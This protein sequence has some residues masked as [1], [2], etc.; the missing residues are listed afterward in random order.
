LGTR[1]TVGACAYPPFRE[2]PRR[3]T[4]GWGTL[5]ERGRSKGGAFGFGLFCLALG[6]RLG[7][8][9]VVLLVVDLL[10]ALVLLLVDLLFLLGVER[11]AVGGAVVVDL[12]GDAGLGLV[13]AGRLA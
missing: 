6:G 7:G 11:A 13:G 1:P 9:A 2:S 5:I 10:G 12:L 8:R 3:P 4:E